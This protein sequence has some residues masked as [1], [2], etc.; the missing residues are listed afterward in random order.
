MEGGELKVSWTNAPKELSDEELAYMQGQRHWIERSFEDA[1]SHVGMGEYQVRKWLGWQHHM[2]LV[3]LAMLFVLEER[4]LAERSHPRLSVRD[5]V[6]LMSWYFMHHPSLEE[7][8]ETMNRRHY[9]RQQLME[10]AEKR[11]AGVPKA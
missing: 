6:E 10:A 11:A 3:G 2:V 4:L 8:Q 1:K 5:V 7:L 9:R